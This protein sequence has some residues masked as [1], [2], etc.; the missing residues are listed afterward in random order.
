MSRSLRIPIPSG[1]ALEMIDGSMDASYYPLT[2]GQCVVAALIAARTG[3]FPRSHVMVNNANDSLAIK[4]DS[5]V[6]LHLE[7]FRAA[8][9]EAIK[10]ETSQCEFHLLRPTLEL[11]LQLPDGDACEFVSHQCGSF[12]QKEAK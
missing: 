10:G 3:E 4:I 9:F 7:E 2:T 11:C 5:L 1:G 12:S 8:L 6:E